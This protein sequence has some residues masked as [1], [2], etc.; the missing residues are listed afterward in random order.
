ME[1]FVDPKLKAL[2]DQTNLDELLQ[3]AS[4]EMDL[5]QP[6]A[7]PVAATP[8]PARSTA[9]PLQIHFA[10][11]DIVGGLTSGRPTSARM[12]GFA[13][14]F[15]GGPMILSGLMLLSVAWSVPVR[16]PQAV[17]GTVFSLG[18]MGFWPYVVFANWRKR[19]K[20]ADQR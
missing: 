13:L 20:E 16:W 19:S 15:L 4:R 7:P 11:A 9:D 8:E 2:V 10:S 12:K 14:A 5:H 17:I 3:P 6:V 1:C 18:L